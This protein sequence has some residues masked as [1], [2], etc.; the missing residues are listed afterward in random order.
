MLLLYYVILIFV[1][2]SVC[3]SCVFTLV[4]T[5][6]HTQCALFNLIDWQPFWWRV[7]NSCVISNRIGDGAES[8]LIS[9]VALHSMCCLIKKQPHIH[10]LIC[11]CLC[12]CVCANI[13]QLLIW[14]STC[15]LGPLL[16]GG[17]LFLSLSLSLSLL[18]L[19]L[20]SAL[21]VAFALPL[22]QIISITI[23]S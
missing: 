10:V 1:S 14:D 3:L 23:I 13:G 8:S 11:V 12:V 2:L 15:V 6:T 20:I 22:H 7:L 4:L 18:S 5:T 17:R 21:T 9:L 19:N 16:I